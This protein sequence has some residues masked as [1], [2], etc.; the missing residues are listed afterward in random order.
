M[1]PCNPK[2]LLQTFNEIFTEFFIVRKLRE[3]LHHYSELIQ[4]RSIQFSSVAMWTG[5][6]KNWQATARYSSIKIIASFDRLGP[7]HMQS[8]LKQSESHSTDLPRSDSS[9]STG[10]LYFPFRLLAPTPT[11][12]TNKNLRNAVDLS[13]P[14]RVLG[15]SLTPI[16]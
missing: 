15:Y 5:C 10:V 9:P 11:W 4:F 13:Q 12:K 1:V 14:S 6:Q 2:I 3:T 7:L 16:S 8:C